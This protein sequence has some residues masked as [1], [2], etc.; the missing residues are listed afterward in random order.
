[1]FVLGSVCSPANMTASGIELR[2]LCNVLPVCACSVVLPDLPGLMFPVV[3]FGK[4]L[5]SFEYN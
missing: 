4:R 3:G 1:M 2:L 5:I